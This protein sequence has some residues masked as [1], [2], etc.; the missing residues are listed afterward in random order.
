LFPLLIFRLIYG[1]ENGTVDSLSKPGLSITP[2]PVHS[3][4]IIVRGKKR[5]T[6][7]KESAFATSVVEAAEQRNRSVDALDMVDNASG[8]RVRRSGGAGSQTEI[9]IDGL[10]GK[11]I[12]FL[13]DGLPADAFGLGLGF[14][15]LP[16]GTLDRIEIYKGVVPIEL[17]TDALGGVINA[18]TRSEKNNHLDV[19]YSRGSFGAN[20]FQADSKYAFGTSRVFLEARGFATHSDNDYPVEV[21]LINPVTYKV[22]A[23]TT[24]VRRFHD[25]YVANGARVGLGVDGKPWADRLSV[26]FLGSSMEKQI[27]NNLNM[28]QPFGHV[29]LTE[30]SKGGELRFRKSGIAEKVDLQAYLAYARV[31]TEY[32]DTSLNSYDWEGN[33]IR[34]RESAGEASAHSTDWLDLSTDQLTGQ[35]GAAYRFAPGQKLVTHTT[36]SYRFREGRDRALEY[37][38]ERKPLAEPNEYTKATGGL[39]HEGIWLAGKFSTNSFLKT[40]WYK[41]EGLTQPDNLRTT[42]ELS[43]TGFGEALKYR[44][45]PSLDARASYEKAIRIPDESELFGFFREAWANLGLKPEKG[46]NFNL[47]M[48]YQGGSYNLEMGTFYRQVENLIYLEVGSNWAQYRNL[49]AAR[50]IGLEG[51]MSWKPWSFLELSGNATYQDIRNR[52]TEERAGGVAARYFNARVPNIPYLFGNLESRYTLKGVFTKEDRIQAYWSGQYIEDFY[53]HWAEDGR[54]DTKAVIPAQWTQN[55]GLTYSPF[56]DHLNFN[57]AVRNLDDSKTYDNYKLQKPGRSFQLKIRA[58]LGRT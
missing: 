57:F 12:R 47:G 18:V 27:Q 24:T 1:V 26:A 36:G 19:S 23:N 43:L 53:L 52:N 22:D 10:S 35:A 11:Q 28:E 16:V 6:Q 25:R 54:K 15:S 21:N 48:R 39:A 38:S 44:F 50:Y 56:H 3:D 14:Q 32:I 46:Q 4:T 40:H 5:S 13:I 49:G 17:G 29:Q 55:L 37:V 41:A 45:T 9:S 7:V 51:E 58:F 31:G 34:I 42:A 30:R 2:K 8:V 20:D 33:V